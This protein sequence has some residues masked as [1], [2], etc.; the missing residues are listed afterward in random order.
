MNSKSGEVLTLV[1]VGLAVGVAA[2]WVDAYGRASER[3]TKTGQYEYTWDHVKEEPAKAIGYPVLGAAAGWGVGKLLNSGG[4]GGRGDSRDNNVDIN[5]DSYVVVN[6]SGDSDIR[7]D[8]DVSNNN[9][10]NSRSAP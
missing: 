3:A 9:E 8:N 6:I 1:L 4:N 10:D 5:S 7:N 2:L